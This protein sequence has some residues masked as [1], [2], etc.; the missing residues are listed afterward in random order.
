VGGGVARAEAAAAVR[1][2]AVRVAVDLQDVDPPRRRAGVAAAQEGLPGPEAAVFGPLSALRAHTKAPHRMDV[3]WNTLR[4][5]NRPKA[6]RTV[7]AW[8]KAAPAMLKI[9]RRGR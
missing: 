9:P 4:T 7:G 3:H 6:A 5:P 2:G 8:S 1:D